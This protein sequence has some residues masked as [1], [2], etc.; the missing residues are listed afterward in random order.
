MSTPTLDVHVA[1]ALDPIGGL[2][3]VESFPTT[4]AG[5]RSLLAWLAGFGPLQRVG[6]EGTG[7][8]VAGLA[9]LVQA[10]GVT[11]VEVDRPDRHQRGPGGPVRRR[12]RPLEGP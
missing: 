6:I 11:V 1:A 3:G 12:H 2:L 8:Y 10:A 4:P 5:C 7:S 9:R